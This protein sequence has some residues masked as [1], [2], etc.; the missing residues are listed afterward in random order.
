MSVAL[1]DTVPHVAVTDCRHGDH[2]PPEGVRDGLE[3]GLLG[4]GLGEVDDARE[5]DHT[6]N[7]EGQGAGQ[8]ASSTSVGLYHLTLGSSFTVLGGFRAEF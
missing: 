8:A 3:E 4:A 1:S 5:E 2:R 6:C 7:R